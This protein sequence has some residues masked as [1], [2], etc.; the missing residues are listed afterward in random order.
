MKRFLLSHS[1]KPIAYK[2]VQLKQR[3]LNKQTPGDV[4]SLWLK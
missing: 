3:P 1:R 4:A 2:I